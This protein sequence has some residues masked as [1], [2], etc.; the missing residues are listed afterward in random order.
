MSSAQC[1]V[2]DVGK[3]NGGIVE[4]GQCCRRVLECSE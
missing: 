4:D 3:R 2:E 1:L